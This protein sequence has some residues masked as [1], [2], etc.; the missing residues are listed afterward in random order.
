VN[1]DQRSGGAGEEL[2]RILVLQVG[3]NAVP[4]EL[5][6][7]PLRGSAIGHG[8]QGD[9]RAIVLMGFVYQVYADDIEA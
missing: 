4:E 1:V 5:G 8:H 2:G 3:W 7:D 6:L 9:H